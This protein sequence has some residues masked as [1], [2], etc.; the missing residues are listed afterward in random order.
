ME[1]E[2]NDLLGIVEHKKNHLQGYWYML[3]LFTHGMHGLYRL[4]NKFLVI[5]GNKVTSAKSKSHNLIYGLRSIQENC[6]ILH[7]LCKI[8]TLQVTWI[9]CVVQFTGDLKTMNTTAMIFK[10]VIKFLDMLVWHDD[11][12]SEFTRN[13]LPIK[14]GFI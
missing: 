11:V 9:G 12:T 7:N 5:Y 6:E 2:I 10:Q 1:E 8:T 3:K 13:G 4:L 14:Y